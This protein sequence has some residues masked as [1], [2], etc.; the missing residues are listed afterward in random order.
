MRGNIRVYERWDTQTR[1]RVDQVRNYS[2]CWSDGY[3]RVMGDYLRALAV[4]VGHWNTSS[5]NTC[6]RPVE[7]STGFRR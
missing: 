1:P 4:E 5:T 3:T 2:A 6:F 7:D